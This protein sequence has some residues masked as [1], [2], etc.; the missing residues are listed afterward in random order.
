MIL[1]TTR[2]NEGHNE[3]I[4]VADTLCALSPFF[5]FLVVK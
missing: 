5:V 2:V 1:L 3:L 4:K